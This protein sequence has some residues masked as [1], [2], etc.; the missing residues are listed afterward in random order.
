[1]FLIT[2]FKTSD[3]ELLVVAEKTGWQWIDLQVSFCRT[4]P[5][6]NFMLESFSSLTP[7]HMWASSNSFT[8]LVICCTS[9]S[10]V[11]SGFSSELLRTFESQV[12]KTDLPF[13]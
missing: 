8:I 1:M 10:F 3:G 13:K 7:L 5:A 6:Q 4:A 11:S 9:V 2:P 12:Q